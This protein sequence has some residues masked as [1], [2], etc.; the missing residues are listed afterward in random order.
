MT[1][2]KP[3][4]HP[5]CDT[6]IRFGVIICRYGQATEGTEVTV[7]KDRGKSGGGRR[8]NESDRAKLSIGNWL[9]D[10]PSEGFAR[11]RRFHKGGKYAR[12]RGEINK[13][14]GQASVEVDVL[15]KGFEHYPIRAYMM[16]AECRQAGA[17]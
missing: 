8:S 13:F 3:S 12:F 4:P 6:K 7:R 1:G 15:C 16:A 17:R 11:M 5:S 9:A 2:S 14:T 10:I